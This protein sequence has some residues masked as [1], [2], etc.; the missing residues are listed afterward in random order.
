N[1]ELEKKETSIQELKQA[2][3]IQELKTQKNRFALM[4]VGVILLVIVVITYLLYKRNKEKNSAN[5]L[6]KEQNTIISQKKQ[7]IESSIHYAKGIQTSF[8]P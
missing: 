4:G 8:F 6:L 5:L 3:E 2:N 7:E 1:Y